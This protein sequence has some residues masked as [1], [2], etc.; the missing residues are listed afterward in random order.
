MSD[1]WS[2]LLTTDM[3]KLFVGRVPKK[4]EKIQLKKGERRNVTVLFLDIKGFTAMSEKLDP[5]E[6]TQIIDNVFKVLT[7]EILRYGGMIDKYI[8]DCIMALYGAKTASEDDAERAIRSALGMLDRMKQVNVILAEKGIDLNCRIGINS[9]LVVAG[10]LG[11]DESKDFTVM[12]DTVNTASRL[13]SNAAVGTIM[14]SDSTR[15]QAGEIFRY[16]ELEPVKVKGKEKPLKVFRVHGVQKERVERWERDSMARSREYIGRDSEWKEFEKYAEEALEKS[17]AEGIRV[18]G[19]RADGGMG[20]SRMVHEFLR[21][22]A[23]PRG[24]ILKGKTISYT[25]AP[26]RVFIGV[27]KNMMGVQEGDPTDTV[28]ERWEEILEEVLELENAPVDRRESLKN[29]LAEIEDYLAYLLGICRDEEGIKSQD[30]NK[31]K[32]KFFS[33]FKAFFEAASCRDGEGEVMYAVLDDLHWV[34][35]LSKEL[36]DYLIESLQPVRK[37]VLVGMYRPD[38]FISER[39]IDGENFREI[40]VKPLSLT[41][42]ADMIERMFPGLRLTDKLTKTIYDKT[43]GNPFYTEEICL[44]LIDQEVIIP[45]GEIQ[46]GVRLWALSAAADSVELP[47]TI[48]GMVQTRIDK[49]AEEVRDILLKA[50]VI[51]QSFTFELLEMLHIKAGGEK[52]DVKPALETCVRTGMIAALPVVPEEYVFSNALIQEVCYNTLLNY[53]KEILNGLVG[54]CL[55]DIYGGGP[56]TIPQ[57]EHYRLADHFEKGNKADKAYP[58]LQSSADTFKTQ[59]SNAAAIDFY[60]RILGSLDKMKM[61]QA[62]KDAIR[63]RNLFS[64]ATVKLLVGNLDDAYNHFAECCK[65]A[66]TS[67]DFDMLCQSLTRAG[68]IDR[69]RSR[70]ENAEKFFNKSLELAKKLGNDF[71]QADNFVNIGILFEE[72]GDYAAAMENFQKALALASTDEQR[73]NISHYIFQQ[74]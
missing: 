13:E 9:G 48:H 41:E 59:F 45:D 8:G 35:E 25:M 49:L 29:S 66:H 71:Y 32:E 19:L 36:I 28:R 46:E 52:D 56:D 34:D 44:S 14:I 74:S 72:Q 2:S 58:Y 31:L 51:G 43:S 22:G 7:S 15:S 11:S 17:S 18:I 3:D 21:R 70:Y 47:D 62:Q 39:W 40:E 24:I 6:V 69:L 4:V 38:Y 1:D 33:G 54:D 27:L 55:E 10:E 53:N 37:T 73:Q 20:K 65:L 5:E 68:E 23:C 60:T 42:T 63:L 26:Y 61:E 57:D 64:I 50:S 16:E 12:G 67:G 30:P